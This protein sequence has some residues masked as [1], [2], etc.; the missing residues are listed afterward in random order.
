M[1]IACY[2]LH[3][4][5]HLLAPSLVQPPIAPRC[6]ILGPSGSSKTTFL[7]RLKNNQY[8]PTVPTNGVNIEE[9]EVTRKTSLVFSDIGGSDRREVR[10][11]FLNSVPIQDLSILYF[12]DAS[13][14]I[15]TLPGVLEE[16][17]YHV[18]YARHR[19]G[20]TKYVGIVLNKQDLIGPR[21]RAYMVQELKT[22]VD[23][24]MEMIMKEPLLEKK[25]DTMM[26]EVLDG[27]KLGISAKTGEGVKEV[28]NTVAKAVFGVEEKH[29]PK[30]LETVKHG[31]MGGHGRLL[32]AVTGHSAAVA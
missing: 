17:V 23:K 20:G 25:D 18:T 29:Q 19:A 6:L 13:A 1:P 8:F 21:D 27:G 22:E 32:G 16:L 24:V 2:C 31:H 30:L 15:D 14:P 26:W 9:L 10:L 7:Y 11:H 5:S 12:V 3:I 28:F 4:R